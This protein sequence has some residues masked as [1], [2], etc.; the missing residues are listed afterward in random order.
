[1]KT[2]VIVLS[3]RPGDWLGA[4][5]ASVAGRCDE[6]LLVD[7]GSPG[8]T[9]SAVGERHGARVVRSTMNRGFAPAVNL[10]AGLATGDILALLND[11][12]VAAEG[13]L[14]A[15]CAALEDDSVAAVGPKLVL[16]EPYLEV[17]L[18]D[19]PW[20]APGDPRPLGRQLRS[21]TVNGEEVLDRLMGPGV[22]LLESVPEGHSWRWTS[23]RAP[24]Y[25]PLGHAAAD[26]AGVVPLVEIDGAPAPAG[27]VVRLVNSAGGFLDQRGYGGDIGAGAPDDG[28][29]GR[30]AERF[31]VSG[32]AFVTT[33]R[34]WR[35]VGPMAA[36][37]FAYYEDVDWCWRAQLMGLRIL[38]DPS[39]T[40]VHR[41]SASSGGEH[42]ENVRV[43]A[44]RNRTLTMVRNGPLALAGKALGA[45]WSQGPDGGVREGVARLLPWA[46]ATRAAAVRHWVRRP[47]DVWQ[48]W[49]GVD[50][51]WPDGPAGPGARLAGDEA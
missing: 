5:L 31:S 43:M 23:G 26:V 34:T 13:W 11:D 10:A 29:F 46:V 38:Y 20:H 12:A 22:H 50:E 47:H 25:V 49:A 30:R 27:P 28:R 6:L 33:A 40:V 35:T 17:V 21:V 32:A 42:R 51:G 16:A 36:P 3:Y 37:F 2:S 18:A 45:R 41:R 39:S 9:A 15:A 44:E 4:C 19:E 14:P 8:G 1:M 24:F 48:Q 7:N